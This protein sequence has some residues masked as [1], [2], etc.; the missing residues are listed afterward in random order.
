MMKNI[1]KINLTLIEIIQDERAEY[2]EMIYQEMIEKLFRNKELET[3]AAHSYDMD[4][5]QYG[6]MH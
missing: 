3:Y 6:T 4:A 5:E 1:D 2:D